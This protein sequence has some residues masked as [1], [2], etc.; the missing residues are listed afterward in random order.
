MINTLLLDYDGTLAPF[1]EDAA[2]KRVKEMLAADLGS[3]S[4]EVGGEFAEIFNALDAVLHSK[5][6][7]R[8]TE[9]I[10]NINSYNVLTSA[11]V[12]DYEIDFRWSRELWLKYLSDKYELGLEGE[13]IM[14]VIDGYWEALA[15]SSPLFPDVGEYLGRQRNLGAYVITASDRRIAISQDTIRYDPSYSEKQKMSRIERTGLCKFINKENIVVGDPFDKPGDMFW[16]KIIA[17]AGIK[18]KKDA[19]VV[20]DSLSTVKSAKAA[21]FRGYV[22]DRIGVYDRN[23]AAAE[24]DG[25][26]TGLDQLAIER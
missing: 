15:D 13:F 3:K 23:Q 10:R 11:D 8:S 19:V 18:D 20:D 5:A 26:I 14:K 2:T 6:D 4:E 22:M 1:N 25:Y 9:V 21:G 24:T 7:S 12:G 16:S 17:K